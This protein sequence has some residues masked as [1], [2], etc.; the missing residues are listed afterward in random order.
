METKPSA[1]NVAKMAIIFVWV[2]VVLRFSSVEKID[3]WYH[4]KYEI[5]YHC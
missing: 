5:R 3:V 4:R 2:R 1:K